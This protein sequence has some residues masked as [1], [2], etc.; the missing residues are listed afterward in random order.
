MARNQIAGLHNSLVYGTPTAQLREEQA[1]FIRS[2][3]DLPFTNPASP[4]DPF[5]PNRP[6]VQRG[7]LVKSAQEY[8]TVFLVGLKLPFCNEDHIRGHFER[9]GAIKVVEIDYKEKWAHLHF[10][11]RSDAEEAVKHPYDGVTGRIYL[12][13]LTRPP[14]HQQ[15]TLAELDAGAAQTFRQD[16]PPLLPV[17]NAVR[18]NQLAERVYPRVVTEPGFEAAISGATNFNP[19]LHRQR[20]LPNLRQRSDTNPFS[21]PGTGFELIPV[22]Q[23]TSEATS[24]SNNMDTKL[25]HLYA[26][27]HDVKNHTSKLHGRVNQQQTETRAM[28][29]QASRIVGHA[30]YIETQASNISKKVEVVPGLL[31]KVHELDTKVDRLH[32]RM[33]AVQANLSN[34]ETRVNEMVSHI[35]I[36]SPLMANTDTYETYTE[37]QSHECQSRIPWLVQ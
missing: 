22:P 13:D 27:V 30:S 35:F 21:S 6:V 16:Y 7:S 29:D 3:P 28:L 26:M 25:A 8:S 15:F 14:M 10:E 34:A 20:S 32:A 12:P 2:N 31:Q 36:K 4:M 1:A 37:S 33:D 5:G 24:S 11:N 17:T 18:E 19:H 9:F 23:N